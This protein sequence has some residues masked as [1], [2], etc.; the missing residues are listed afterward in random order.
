MIEYQ[1]QDS[2]VHQLHPLTKLAFAGTMMTLA[3][4]FTNPL[5]LIVVIALV[6]ISSTIAKIIKQSFSYLLMMAFF[7]VIVFLLQCLFLNK[8]HVYFTVF[9]SSWP[10]VGG[11]VPI[12]HGGLMLGLSMALRVLAIVS[13]FPLIICTTQPRDIVMS[14][15]E[16][17]KVPYDYAFMF[18]TALRFIPII[19]SEVTVIYQAQL[20]RAHAVDGWNPIKKMKAFAPIAFPIV[21]IAIEKADRLGLSM[22][23]RGYH[24]GKRTYYKKLE[25]KMPDMVFLALMLILICAAIWMRLRD[26]GRITL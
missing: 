19:I 8:G 16:N 18:T 21:F 14:L 7:A 12:S 26:I 1:Y 10:V 2:I 25:F 5:Y 24:S 20:S 22:E 11:W 17:L 4:L 13:A 9:P 6:I 3:M 23:L 15:V